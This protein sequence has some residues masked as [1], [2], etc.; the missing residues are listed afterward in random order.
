MRRGFQTEERACAKSESREGDSSG[1]LWTVGYS[2]NS[3][4]GEQWFEAGK[5]E[6][7]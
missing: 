3:G 2:W 6:K 4:Y 5:V 1:E 7:V